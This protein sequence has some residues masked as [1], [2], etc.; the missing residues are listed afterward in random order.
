MKTLVPPLLCEKERRGREYKPVE[1]K[2]VLTQGAV[3]IVA[4]IAL[5]LFVEWM[6]VA[7]DFTW[8]PL[9]YE[10]SFEAVIV[11]ASLAA[12]LGWLTRAL[13][14]WLIDPISRWVGKRT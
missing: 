1:E 14:K 7:E 8:L 2:K 13:Q 11:L 4:L 5:I 9:L 3:S 12:F 10:F 6:T